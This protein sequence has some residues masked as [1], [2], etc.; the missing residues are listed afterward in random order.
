MKN[1][2]KIA[3][4]LGLKKRLSEIQTLAQNFKTV[5]ITK[6]ANELQSFNQEELI[7][8]R[9]N[10]QKKLN[11]NPHLFPGPLGSVMN[12]DVGENKELLLEIERSRFDLY[13]GLRNIIP[14]KIDL[15][16]KPL[17]LNF[18][19]P[20][21]IGAVTVTVDDCIIFGIRSK[22]AAFEHG[23][24][25]SL[26][27][28]YY[29]PDTDY[30]TVGDPQLQ[31]YFRSIRF[32]IIKELWEEIGI[33]DFKSLE[34]LGMFHADGGRNPLIAMTLKLD[35]TVKQVQSIARDAGFEIS[36]YHYIANTLE[37]TATFIEKH[38]PTSHDVAKIIWHFANQP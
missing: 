19:W 33:Q 22:S 36:K 32:T 18:P 15:S 31:R 7:I 38:P 26:P 14:S 10:W 16:K 25:T 24:S 21:S 13:D 17:D 6:F 12:F 2:E 23:Q 35:L 9:E 37:D 4:D 29:D 3:E 8:I 5:R 34:Y 27:S 30:I 1:I 11:S 20:L 28:G